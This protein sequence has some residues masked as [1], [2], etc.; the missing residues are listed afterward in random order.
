MEECE[1]CDLLFK[2][3]KAIQLHKET[4]HK[5][6]LKGSSQNIKRYDFSK[7]VLYAQKHKKKQ[8]NL[9][10]SRNFPPPENENVQRLVFECL[11]CSLVFTN[12]EQ[13]VIHS[14]EKHVYNDGEVHAKV[15]CDMCNKIFASKSDLMFHVTFMN[16]EHEFVLCELCPDQG[17]T[18]PSALKQHKEKTHRSQ[19]AEDK[20]STAT[21]EHENVVV[22]QPDTVSIDANNSHTVE[23]VGDREKIP[24]KRFKRV[25][26]KYSF[27]VQDIVEESVSKTK[28]SLINEEE[29]IDIQNVTTIQENQHMFSQNEKFP[30]Y[31]PMKS[32]LFTKKNHPSLRKHLN[33][34]LA[35]LGKPKIPNEDPDEEEK[36]ERAIMDINDGI[37]LSLNTETNFKEHSRQ[38]YRF[39]ALRKKRN[40]KIKKA[41][42]IRHNNS[43]AKKNCVIP[44]RS[45]Y[46]WYKDPTLPQGWRK[47]RQKR[48]KKLHQ[49]NTTHV[50][51]YYLSPCGKQVRSLAEMK[52]FIQKQKENNPDHNNEYEVMEGLKNSTEA[53]SSEDSEDEK[54]ISDLNITNISDMK[55]LIQHEFIEKE[56]EEML[57]DLNTPVAP[58]LPIAADLLSKYKWI[59]APDLPAGWKKRF[60]IRESSR[61]L[62][63]FFLSP[64]GKQFR[65]TKEVTAFLSANENPREKYFVFPQNKKSMNKYF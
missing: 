35:G 16:E 8:T 12:K 5:S 37:F 10:G 53:C 14:Y 1:K 42:I 4:Y 54:K 44:I 25:G 60:L 3:K 62:D 7:F 11:I 24:K 43:I 47:R 55:G 39:K 9:S 34:L 18:I 23:H 21:L 59:D 28:N 33:Y 36:I 63:C 48:N 41:K 13:F 26:G 61:H 58:L 40:L 46:H 56:V 31:N 6:K 19:D 20:H 17:V 27:T 32:P 38:G 51:H 65:S 22:E 2:S 15:V 52:T 29:G 49:T 57:T 30:Y 45:R 50:D 64:C